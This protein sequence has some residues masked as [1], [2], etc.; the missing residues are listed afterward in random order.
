[1]LIW[2][3]T[4]VT[5]AVVTFS[6]LIRAEQSRAEQSRAEQSRAEQSRAEQSRAEQSRAEQSRAEQSRAHSNHFDAFNNPFLLHNG[7]VVI[8]IKWAS[9]YQCLACDPSVSMFNLSQIPIVLHKEPEFTE[10]GA[11][12]VE[13]DGKQKFRCGFRIGGG[14]DQDPTKSPQGYPDK[15][16]CRGDLKWNTNAE[17]NIVTWLRHQNLTDSWIILVGAADI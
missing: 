14:I 4:V 16:C 9:N 10:Q 7:C 6:I 8:P 12:V 11:A 15:V 5:A 2:C 17:Q 13:L 1:M 3:N